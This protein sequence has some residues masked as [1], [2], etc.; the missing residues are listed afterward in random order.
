MKNIKALLILFSL[1]HHLVKA[2]EV[3]PSLIASAINEKGVNAVVLFDNTQFFIEKPGYSTT[4]KHWAV[5]VFNEEAAKEHGLFKAYY[6]KFSKIKR[7]DGSLYLA[8]GKAV[9]SLKTRDVDEIGLSAFSDG[10]SD[11]M[12]KFG[13]F[14]NMN[15]EYP[16]VVEFSFEKQDKN[17]LFYPGWFPQNHEKT[18]VLSSSFTIESANIPFRFKEHKTSIPGLIRN[19]GLPFKKS[20]EIKNVAP[21]EYE[22]Y[23]KNDDLPWVMCAPEIFE[24][25]EYTGTFKTWADIGKFYHE[26]NLNRDELPASSLQK[27]KGLIAPG[28]SIA[29]KTKAVYEYM[30]SHTRYMSIQL[31]IGG[32]Q[33]MPATMV[34]EKGYGDCK[35]LTNYTIALLK[36]VGV[37]AYPALVYAGDSY[38]DSSEDF[39]S[40]NFNHV[41]ACVPMPKDTIWLE[42]TSQTEPLGYQGN[43]TGNRKALLITPN[44]S[45]LVN[46][47]Q[48]TP[49]NNFQRRTA[50][51]WLEKDGK[52]EVKIHST[53]GGLQQE[54]RAYIS[55]NLNI[56]EQR[57]Y[58]LG[59]IDIP[60]FELQEFEYKVLKSRLPEV[61]EK[62]NVSSRKLASVSGKRMFLKPNLLSSFYRTPV[63]REGRESPFY[64]DPNSYSFED[65]DEI[66]FHIPEG[67]KTEASPKD[68]TIESSFGYYSSS[69]ERI[70]NN[71]KYHRKIRVKGGLYPTDTYDEWIQ[72]VKDVNRADKQRVVLINEET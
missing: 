41:I 3:S 18:K 13:Q 16:F 23:S 56:D 21:F 43:F 12:V 36:N 68:I 47:T 5:M 59:S 48:Y 64:L 53:Y 10:I 37:L 15:Y 70:E 9:E 72:F 55:Q 61:I 46:T 20:W 58:L 32:W 38:D 71:L 60:S 52:A 50:E 65:S 34:A 17:M 31:G 4:K 62:A 24:I 19:V 2:Q 29:E 44:G 11:N 1:C 27:L 57:K 66:I 6:D 26:L 7:I 22:P 49:E 51:V 14:D 63:K 42:C 40:M 45:E 54:K 35:A 69:I 67:L 33:T 28:M 25:D 30:Q 39:P 8:N